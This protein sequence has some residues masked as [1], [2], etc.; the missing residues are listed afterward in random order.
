MPV[1]SDAPAD[2]YRLAWEALLALT[3]IYIAVS[4]GLRRR[5][6]RLVRV[7]RYEPPQGITPAAAA[8]LNEGGQYERP[9][10]AAL[11]SLA[12]KNNIKILQTPVWVTL[13]KLRTSDAQLPP[14][15][16]V[17]F[18]SLFPTDD[19]NSYSFSGRDCD[20]LFAAYRLFRETLREMMTAELVS[21]HAVIWILGLTYS[22]TVLV[23]IAISMPK[24]GNG[25]QLGSIGF[26]G[27]LIFFGGTC[28]IAAL[29]VWPATLLKVI[30]FMPGS[31]R[32]KSSITWN[33]GIAILLT[34][35]ALAG[36]MFLAALTSTKF[37][38][39]AAAVVPINVF[40][41]YFLN[42][43]T[44]SGRKVLAELRS[45]REFLSRTD[46]DRLNHENEPG[47]T[48]RT[49]EPYIAY[50]VALGVEHGWGEE[51][52]GNLLEMLQ[53]NQAYSPP[54]SLPVPDSRPTDLNLFD[55]NR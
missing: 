53:A 22:V 19:F 3:V 44:S 2:V 47:R 23:L 4:I 37:A 31:S 30:S 12:A 50:A 52:A 10:A 55:R 54:G 41:R 36:F 48:P 38:F 13:E 6:Q 24:F 42:A 20:R 51:F 18:S 21:S 14:E 26:M 33:D 34:V 29:R 5:T 45:F 46:A 28:F 40:G 8:F 1:A 15:E 25:L 16:S 27:I 17:V 35:Y 9:F 43:P 32:P 39:V 7:T 11:V 49:L